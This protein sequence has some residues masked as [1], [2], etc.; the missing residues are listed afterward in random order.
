MN[1]LQTIANDREAGLLQQLLPPRSGQERKLPV[2]SLILEPAEAILEET[3]CRQQQAVVLDRFREQQDAAGC[4][5][6][7]QML[8]RHTDIAGAVQGVVRHDNIVHMQL[9]ALR[10]R[11][12]IHIEP[13]IL[14]QTGMFMP[15]SRPLR[16]EIG[17]VRIPITSASRR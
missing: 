15:F 3:G 10:L 16:E 4:Q 6:L 7:P 5:Q 8:Q 13:P 11:I 17:F 2:L 12:L 14:Q 9:I 1:A